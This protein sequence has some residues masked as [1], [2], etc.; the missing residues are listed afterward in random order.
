MAKLVINGAKK[1]HG[2]IDIQGAKNSVLP[3]LAATLLCEDVSL[4]QNCPSLTDVESAVEILEECGCG[5]KREN[6][7]ITVDSS[8]AAGY[9]ISEDLMRKMRSSIMFL[10]PL[11]ARFQK[12][13]INY[14][15]GCELGPRPIDLHI[16]SL[17]K[18]GV[19]FREE[20]GFLYCD[21]PEKLR[22]EK[23][24]LSFPSVGAT[25]NI[26]LC[27]ALCEGATTIINPAKEPEII[28]LQN[29]LNRMGANIRGAGSSIIVIEGVKKLKGVHY[30]VMPD[31]I[32]AAT[33]LCAI[34]ASGG[35]GRINKVRAKDMLSVL[36]TLEQSGCRVAAD[37]DKIYINAKNSL[38]GID[39][40]RTMPYPGFPTDAQPIF[41]AMLA[42]AESPSV[43][44]ETIFE[45]R[46]SYISEL[47]RFGA[48]IRVE[49][50]VCIIENVN[51][52]MG[53][54][55][56]AADLRG[57]AA[58]VV[59]GL[60]SEGETHIENIHYIDRGYENIEKNIRKLSG[61]II[62]T[63]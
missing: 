62:R 41:V 34:A 53:A 3:I 35:N 37:K 33:Y 30:K 12:A 57:G 59:A 40:I 44:I 23:I 63:D 31:R 54:N 16:S 9:K 55:V 49:G 38:S 14:P 51:R 43:F 32:V 25:E 39:S 18:L 60:S 10:G 24:T 17:K 61:D 21:V 13:V 8:N 19:R 27:A 50:R 29:M 36:D 56:R 46:Y 26:M 52:L 11:I 5:V 6:D 20:H 48:K 45:N 2:E 28:D 42:K 22:G 1:L 15:G 58:L 4:I 7:K 47:L